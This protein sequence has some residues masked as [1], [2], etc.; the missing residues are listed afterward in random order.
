MFRLSNGNLSITQM[1]RW[2]ENSRTRIWSVTSHAGPEIWVVYE[3]EII[4]RWPSD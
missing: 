4:K 2:F 1:A 3:T